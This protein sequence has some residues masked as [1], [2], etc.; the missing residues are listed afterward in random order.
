VDWILQYLT[1]QHT[2]NPEGG[3]TPRQHHS[4]IRVGFFEHQ[5]AVVLRDKLYFNRLEKSI[6]AF[7]NQI[8]PIWREA[9]KF[10]ER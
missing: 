3:S 9:Q 8:V 6:H 10:S 2:V 7:Q 5:M 1:L 4:A